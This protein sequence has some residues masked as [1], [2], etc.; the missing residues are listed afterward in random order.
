MQGAYS[1]GLCLF[2]VVWLELWVLDGPDVSFAWVAVKT[3]VPS[4]ELELES[5]RPSKVSLSGSLHHAG[6]ET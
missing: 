5:N 1:I 3:D 6:T 2:R 4:A